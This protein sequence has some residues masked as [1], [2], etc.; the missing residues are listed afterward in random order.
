MTKANNKLCIKCN[1]H[2]RFI[3][4][5]VFEKKIPFYVF[6]IKT[7]RNFCVYRYSEL[8]HYPSFGVYRYLKLKRF[9]SFA[10]IVI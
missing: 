5:L 4:G 10:F 9:T 6:T 7:L 8:K 3:P 2:F 1:V